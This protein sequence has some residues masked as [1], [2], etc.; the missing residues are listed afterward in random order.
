MAGSPGIRVLS[1]SDDPTVR[2]TRELV[3][4]RNGYEILSVSSNDL[5]G[6]AQ[7]RSFDV[8]VMCY[9]V[10]QARAM[11]VADRLRRY[12]PDVRLLRVNSRIAKV[13]SCYDADSDVLS[14][15]ENL[16]KAVKRLLDKNAAPV[17][18]KKSQLP[19]RDEYCGPLPNVKWKDARVS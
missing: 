7:I 13:E 14:G 18:L 16:L 12:K 4:R 19:A 5:L 1:I 17:S 10:P 2:L 11:A 8:V 3:L 9:S 15:P 6:V